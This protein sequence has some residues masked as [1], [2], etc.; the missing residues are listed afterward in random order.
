M[1]S[2]QNVPPGYDPDLDAKP[3]TKA[4]K[5]NERKKEKRQQVNLLSV[6]L[7]SLNVCKHLAL[8]H[9]HFGKDNMGYV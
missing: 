6:S 2:L 9:S 5:R 3:K 8:G 4:A 7:S 1:Q